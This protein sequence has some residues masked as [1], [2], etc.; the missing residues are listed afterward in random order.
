MI[1]STLALT[2]TYKGDRLTEPNT[3]CPT[4]CS[5]YD[6]SWPLKEISIVQLRRDW[7]GAASSWRLTSLFSAALAPVACFYTTGLQRTHISSG[8][9]TWWDLFPP[10]SVCSV[11]HPF[12]CDYLTAHSG[13]RGLKKGSFG[14]SF[15]PSMPSDSFRTWTPPKETP[16]EV[17]PPQEEGSHAEA[18]WSHA[19][20]LLVG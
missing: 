5:G 20:I 3:A 13:V 9:L 8:C 1:S 10:L 7:V 12:S 14:K 4:F 18:P 19:S 17:L 6:P 2:S 11:V 16:E 15:A